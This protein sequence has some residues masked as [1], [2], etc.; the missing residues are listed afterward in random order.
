MTMNIGQAMEAMKTGSVVQRAIWVT[1]NRNW[2]LYYT[3]AVNGVPAADFT[4]AALAAR[5]AAQPGGVANV[6]AAIYLVDGAN[7]IHPGW[8][9]EQV[10]L[11]AEDWAVVS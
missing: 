8:A 10:D 3:A 11:F 7:N 4:N 5:V 6:T 1:Q 9:A 2:K